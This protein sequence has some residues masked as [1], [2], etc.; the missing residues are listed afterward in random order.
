MGTSVAF[1][2]DGR[3]PTFGND[4]AKIITILVAIRWAIRVQKTD[5]PGG[6]IQKCF[7]M[8][9]TGQNSTEIVCY[10]LLEKVQIGL[11]KLLVSEISN[12]KIM[13]ID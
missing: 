8:V 3:I 11:N 4:P 7:K 13:N 6:T 5:I 1:L 10:L 2:Y 12:V 9:L